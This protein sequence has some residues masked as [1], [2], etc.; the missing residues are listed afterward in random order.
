MMSTK[1]KIEVTRPEQGRK[2]AEPAGELETL[3]RR[4]AELEGRADAAARAE[5]TLA[6]Q[7]ALMQAILRNLPFDFWARD[8]DGKIIMQSDASVRLWGDLAA[9]RVEETDI[10]D[11]IR[12]TWQDIN[13]RVYAGEVVE[14]E[15]KY[16]L[17]SGETRFYRDIVAPIRMGDG[18]LGILG[19]NVDITE[20][21]RSIRALHASQANL[22]SLLDSIDESAALLE[23]DGKVITV[24][25]T[26]A[27]RVGKTVEECLGRSVYEFIST[28]VALSRKRMV[29]DLVRNAQPL[30]FEDERQGLWM[31]HSL[32]PV[33]A[34]DG[35]VAAIATFAVD[36]TERKR[37][38]NL[39]VARQRIVEYA[40]NHS[41]SDL[42]R[43]ALD[44][45]ENLTGSTLSFLHFLNEDQGILSMQA[46][47]TKTLQTGFSIPRDNLDLEITQSRIWSE[48]L[49]TR[50]A[51][52]LNDQTMLDHGKGLPEGHPRLI[53]LVLLPIV[54]A[55]KI[56]A[57]LAVANKETDYTDEDVQVLIELGN[58]LWDILEYKRA[59]EELAKSEA[60]LNMVQRLSGMGGW[61]WDV[62][63]N[64]MIWTRE[65]YRLHGFTPDQVEPGSPEHI[66]LSLACYEPDDRDRI[67]AAFDNSVEHGAPF[68]LEMPFVSA[69]GKRMRIRTRAEAIREGGQV[70]KV[71][72]IFEDV[73]ERRILEQRYETLFWHMLDGFALH[74]I[75]LDAEGRPVD[76]RFL[77]VN[78]AFE[79]H[80]G[81]MASDI[82]GRT[83]REVMPAI[84]QVWIDTYGRVAL[85]GEPLLFEEYA[86]AQ[87]KYFHVTAFRPAP[88]Q[89]ACI[90][91][92][93]SERKRH[94]RDLRQAKEAA[95]AA[96]VAKS[97]FL[98]NM[99]HEIRTPL[100]GIVGILQLL[101]SMELSEEHKKLV[102][103]AGTSAD[104][105]NGLLSDILDLAR[106]ES[107]K[108]T[109]ERLPFDPEELR[110]S[111]LGLFT[112]TSR[113]KGLRLE[114]ALDP[115]LPTMVVGDESRLRQV[116]F[117]L[118][119][120]SI[121][122]TRTG[123]VRVD[124]S[125]V[126]GCTSSM[127]LFCVSDSGPGIP[128]HQLNEI[129]SPFVQGE[130]SYVRNHQ[131]AGL[132]LAIVKR[133][134]TLMDGSLCVDS[135]E[136]G[137]VMC[138]SIV[139]PE[140]CDA[141]TPSVHK[142]TSA[143]GAR[144]LNILLVED[145]AVSMF[146]V[147]RVLEKAGH[148]VTGVG[149]GSEVVPT[150]REGDFDLV[151]MDVQLPILD[152]LQ[153]TIQVRGDASLGDKSRI[154]I[155]A[156]TAY[157]MSG[158]REK[159]LS[160]GMDDYIAKPI[161]ATELLAM[162]DRLGALSTGKS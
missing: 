99:S 135:S 41:L 130:D 23:L 14:G 80:T 1:E 112:P 10:P 52:I 141:R 29:E 27:S 63:Q 28:E 114:F 102:E 111:T 58:L 48:C 35:S 47:S 159:F 37:R 162:L 57:I 49:R 128:D 151:I 84:E 45:T 56:V 125:P 140:V 132:G 13:A 68:D 25:R 138:F 24:N 98:A 65:L 110:A 62:R 51:V 50:N 83:A 5:E 31:R 86:A 15:K 64:S 93:V 16:V 133:I 144:R 126:P 76:Y 154:P 156:M 82:K 43:M 116:L 19:T 40:I 88:M 55:R 104:R 70:S 46:W 11:T 152:G 2:F 66:R 117:N 77:E 118:V 95:E 158:D 119:G 127:V 90:F 123:F 72:G 18:L 109:I 4:V 134:V 94:E 71:L 22:A 81:L 3:R 139:M 136:K 44:E 17:P 91:S 32:S 34:P 6:R 59:Q 97:E 85:T 148:T 100:N 69:T 106:I 120:N 113:S 96:N 108:L 73:T 155:V 20:Q 101:D 42:L 67:L 54:R 12:N 142:A 61:L 153:A 74:E 36:I 30:V 115:A 79:R 7:D 121:K 39:L 53:R 129:F 105:L 122:F 60:L 145:D 21:V 160:A 78:P 157:A 146:A 8:L 89:F 124:V 131:G 87:D 9:S 38:E 161:N 149:D 92:D 75:I 150:L 143:P 33:L 147:Q 103:L 107:G 137:T 26:F